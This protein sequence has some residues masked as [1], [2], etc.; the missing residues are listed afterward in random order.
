MKN[1]STQIQFKEAPPPPPPGWWGAQPS[2]QMGKFNCLLHIYADHKIIST[3]FSERVS[4]TEI[5]LHARR[6]HHV[7]GG[8][9]VIDT[10][11]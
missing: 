5:E 4:T 10:I 7:I 2:H 1:K 3:F 8:K 11:Y 6:M 9:G